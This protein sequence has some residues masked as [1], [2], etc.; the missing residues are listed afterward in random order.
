MSSSQVSNYQP[1]RLFLNTSGGSNVFPSVFDGVA[2]N[3]DF[4]FRLPNAIILSPQDPHQIAIAVESCSIP[5]SYYSID[6]PNNK[7][8]LTIIRQQTQVLELT[9]RRG[10]YRISQLIIELNLLLIANQVSDVTFIFDE[11]RS[12]IAIQSAIETT[13]YICQDTANSTLSFQLGFT[14]STDQLPAPIIFI[15]ADGDTF[16]Q[17]FFEDVVDLIYTSG[18]AICV[19]SLNSRNSTF[20]ANSQNG[21]TLLRIPLTGS[22][23]TVQNYQTSNPIYTIMQSKHMLDIRVSLRDDFG[24]LLRLNGSH[25]IVIVLLVSFIVLEP[26]IIPDNFFETQRRKLIESRAKDNEKKS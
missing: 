7:F 8:S 11:I 14:S 15:N 1:F 20:T 18:V 26:M 19:D 4:T 2:S 25:T 21:N 5:L 24:N 22:S 13:R 6:T 9:V 12:K 3:V 10:N 23:N 17:S 16:Y